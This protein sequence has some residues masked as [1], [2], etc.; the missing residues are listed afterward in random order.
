MSQSFWELFVIVSGLVTVLAIAGLAYMGVKAYTT[1]SAPGAPEAFTAFAS[2]L[3][4]IATVIAIVGTTLTLALKEK[5]LLN[6]AVTGILSGIAGYV[7]GGAEK[8]SRLP[9]PSQKQP[10]ARSE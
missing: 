8:A 2:Q 9:T 1:G 4:R 10:S 6:A 7:L 3:L 5:D